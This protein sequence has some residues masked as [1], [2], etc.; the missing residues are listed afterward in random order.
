MHQP[1]RTD[2]LEADA[3]GTPFGFARRERK[4]GRFMNSIQTDLRALLVKER[5]N[6]VLEEGKR[7]VEHL[8]EE[9]GGFAL[10]GAGNTGLYTRRFLEEQGGLRP[11][12]VVDNNPSLWGRGDI[13]SPAEFFALEDCPP[14]LVVAVYVSDQVVEQA[15]S[16]GYSGEISCL[17]AAA[18]YCGQG[19]AWDLYEANFS[20]LEET[21]RLLAD[22]RSQAT[23]VGFLNYIRTL[24]ECYLRDINGPS[25]EKLVAADML[26]PTDHECFVDVGAF[27]GDTIKAFLKSTGGAYREILALEPDAENYRA[28][29]RYVGESGLERITLKQIAAGERDGT[30]HFWGGM[31]ES[32]RLTENGAGSV[33]VKRL[34]YLPEAQ[35]ATILKISANGMELN[36]LKGAERLLRRNLPKI[37][38]YASG[39]LL[40]EI[41]A[42]IQKIHPD[43]Q[44]CYRHYGFGRQAMICYAVP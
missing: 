36:V 23:L 29:C 6:R 12:C 10:W 40:W 19:N 27:T 14:H 9:P 11:R 24:D 39:T 5:G 13:I 30:L 33:E 43:Y 31:S 32:C 41:P 18:L 26:N 15:R 22:E 1:A 34:D 44:I 42:Y 37:S 4:F 38:T 17:N 21:Y 3:P 28:L 35:G 16:S 25:G 2:L 20:R 8:T 7:L